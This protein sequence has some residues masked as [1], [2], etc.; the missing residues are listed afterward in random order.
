MCS[1]DLNGNGLDPDAVEIETVAVEGSRP[2][3]AR[4]GS[5][6]HAMLASIRLDD[7]AAAIGAMAALHGRLLGATP[8]EVAAATRTVERALGHPVMRRAAAAAVSGTCRREARILHRRD[9]GTVVEAVCDLAFL[10]PDG[11]W[12]VVDFKTDFELE[13]QLERYRRQLELYR[14]AIEA[15]TGAAARALLLRI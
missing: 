11:T 9:D 2:R 13:G 6:V 7:A 5:L 8:E 4:F 1:S 14:E 15:A 10:E 3:G 12:T